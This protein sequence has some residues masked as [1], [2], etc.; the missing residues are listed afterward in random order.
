MADYLAHLLLFG[1]VP[2]STPSQCLS[3]CKMKLVASRIA[4]ISAAVAV[5]ETVADPLVNI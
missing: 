3:Y 4:W 5:K 2:S 1:M